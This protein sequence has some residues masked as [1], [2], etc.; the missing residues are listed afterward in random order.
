MKKI[1]HRLKQK[2]EEERRHILHI[3]T[4]VIAII[5]IALWAWSLGRSVS[6]PNTQIKVKQDLEPFSILKDS[7]VNSTSG[8]Q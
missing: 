8:S 4:F 7:I 5:M 2:P 6:N 1:I 3:A